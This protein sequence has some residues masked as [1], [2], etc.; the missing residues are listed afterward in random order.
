MSKKIKVFHH[1]DLDGYGAL[2]MLLVGLGLKLKDVD[3][4]EINYPTEDKIMKD[5]IESEVWKLYDEI[6][7]LD[8]CFNE[9]I[10][11]QIENMPKLSSKIRVIDHHATNLSK[12][13]Y[14]FVE[15]TEFHEIN[16]RACG[17]SL[18]YEEFIQGEKMDSKTIQYFCELVRLYDT[19]DDSMKVNPMPKHLNTI[20]YDVYEE[21]YD[22]VIA[23]HERVMVEDE[24]GLQ[25]TDT[26]DFVVKKIRRD[27]EKYCKKKS[28]NITKFDHD[29]KKFVF[30]YAEQYHNEVADYI[31]EKYPETDGVLLH[32]ASRE[33][34]S[35]RARKEGTDLSKYAEELGGGGHPKACGFQTTKL[36]KQFLNLKMI[37]TCFTDA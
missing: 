10:C 23:M 31:C 14:S 28:W 36:K 37:Q 8:F 33:S 24:I 32:D 16:K 12:N 25:F 15:V 5:F 35:F 27:I 29:N 20:L 6:Y 4:K 17:A 18:I 7:V 19:W 13:E 2:L 11:Q 26:E 3:A 21:K 34:F 9:A 30:V 22:F 1:L